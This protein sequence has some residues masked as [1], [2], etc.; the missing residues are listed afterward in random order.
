MFLGIL[1]FVLGICIGSFLN[2]YICRWNGPGSIVSP[3]YS[4]CPKC[5]HRLMLFDLIP[6][7]SFIFLKGHCR[8]CNNKI[9]WQYSLVELLTGII[10]LL[11][12]L[13]LE[14]N[15]TLLPNLFFV[16]LLITA[17][18]IDLEQ[19]IIPD[20]LNIWGIGLGL[21]LNLM[22]GNQSLVSMFLGLLITGGLMLLI[23]VLSRGGMG[24]GDIKFAAVIGTFL[25]WSSG[26]LCLFLAFLLGGLIGT[27]LLV[28]K[29]K[30]RKDMLPFGPF[31][32]LAAVIV[33]L[34]G[35]KILSWYCTIFIF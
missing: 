5:Q 1:I 20:K 24:G 10:F 27:F 11:T 21:I 6:L 23:A 15:W 13:H 7:F 35:E 9:N 2:V 3:V 28:F 12:Y 32:S 4:Y 18:F 33:L 26:L 29:I 19:Q 14:L 25:G 22:T 30:E 16:C 34:F 8:Y 17:T 31:L